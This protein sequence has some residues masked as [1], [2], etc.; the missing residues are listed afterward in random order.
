MVAIRNGIPRVVLTFASVLLACMAWGAEGERGLQRAAVTTDASRKVALVIGNAAYGRDALANPVIDAKSMAAALKALGFDVVTITDAGRTQMVRALEEFRRRLTGSGVGLF[1]FAGHGV[2]MEGR[3]YLLP[4]DVDMGSE[5]QVKYNTIRLDDVMDTLEGG[6][7][8]VKIVILDAC[9]NNPFERGRGGSGGLAAVANAP[10]GTL[11]AFATSPGRVAL[12]GRPGDNGLYTRHLLD[13]LSAPGLSIVEVFMATR[14][15]VMRASNGRQ[16][17][18]ETTSL[19]GAPLVLKPGAPAGGA[20]PVVARAETAVASAVR[21]FER[22]GRPQSLAPGARFRDCER[23][24]EMVVVPGGLF[25]M[26][27]PPGERDRRANEGPQRKVTIARPFAVGRFEVTFEEWEACLLDGGCDR[28][29]ADQGWGRGKRPVIDV[30]WEDAIR[31]V[32]WL[33]KRS[34]HAYRLLSEAEWEYVAR[35]GSAP[36]A[37][38]RTLPVTD[39]SLR[40]NQLG[41]AGVLG[42]VWEWVADCS[43]PDY[44]GADAPSDGRARET[45]NCALRGLRG[46]SFLTA[47]R[48]LR[49]AARSFYPAGRRDINIGLRVAS[50]IE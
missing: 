23:C 32:A 11:I 12:D 44:G 13:A 2:Q 45:G 18:W 28:W 22:K 25:E 39:S 24:P 27:S 16:L 34:G 50:A 41:L 10:Q 47:P 5:D 46:G 3:N 40:P 21:G 31:Y 20:G 37:G 30:S 43:N 17:P 7:P 4:V 15:A 29:P 36:A 26:G 6:A 49:P 9:R 19:V 14:A 8:A 48:G 38:E 1:Y 42:N 35:A 33:S